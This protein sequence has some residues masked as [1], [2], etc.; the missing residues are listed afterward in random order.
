[1]GDWIGR[2]G[3]GG[4][5]SS[6]Y[7]LSARN[8][9]QLN[10]RHQKVSEQFIPFGGTITDLGLHSDIWIRNDLSFSGGVQYEKWLFPIL[11]PGAQSNVTTSIQMTF[12][13]RHSRN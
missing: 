8:K 13:P 6:T 9:I 12:W 2:Q 7:W 11:S 10:F 3:Q 1:M 5:A 4:Q